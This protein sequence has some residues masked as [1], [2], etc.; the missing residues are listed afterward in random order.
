MRLACVERCGRSRRGR[1]PG[2][3]DPPG[4]PHLSL[5]FLGEDLVA[6]KPH[7]KASECQLL[8]A[9]SHSGELP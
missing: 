4:C 5:H 8:T 6:T 2:G 9:S 3:T 1:E 7:R